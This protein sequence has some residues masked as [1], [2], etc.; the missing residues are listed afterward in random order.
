MKRAIFILAIILYGFNAMGQSILIDVTNNSYDINFQTLSSKGKTCFL[1]NTI[2]RDLVTSNSVSNL[3]IRPF[4]IFKIFGVKVSRSNEKPS[5]NM[6]SLN[7]YCANSVIPALVEDMKVNLSS[8]RQI[9]EITSANT[10][11]SLI[12]YNKG[13]YEI[14]SGLVLAEFF[15]LISFKQINALQTNRTIIN[16][17]ATPVTIAEWVGDSLPVPAIDDMIDRKMFLLKRNGDDFTF[18]CHPSR[19][20]DSP[21][22]FY[23]EYVYRKGYGILAFKSKYLT[24]AKSNEKSLSQVYDS[25]EYYYFR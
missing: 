4:I 22:S 9:N 17:D 12:V 15:N 1:V 2:R 19:A 18:F 11:D 23:N 16:T 7:D 13:I 10:F 5:A 14:Y 6:T 20:S 24:K 8:L 25:D 3:A 21:L